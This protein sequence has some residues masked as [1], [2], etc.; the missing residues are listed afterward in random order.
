MIFWLDQEAEGVVILYMKII[1]CPVLLDL[2]NVSIVL[3]S[4]HTVLA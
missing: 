3:F 1:S 4:V 2:G